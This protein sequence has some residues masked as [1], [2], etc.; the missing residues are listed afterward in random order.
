MVND[1]RLSHKRN[2]GQELSCP[3]NSKKF[4]VLKISGTF[5]SSK[6]PRILYEKF[7]KIFSRKCFNNLNPT[8]VLQECRR[9]T[10]FQ[11]E[12]N[13][14]RFLPYIKTTSTALWIGVKLT[15]FFTKKF[16]Y[17]EHVYQRLAIDI[18]LVLV[19]TL[20]AIYRNSWMELIAAPIALFPFVSAI[21]DMRSMLGSKEEVVKS[22]VLSACLL[23]PSMTEEGSSFLPCLSVIF[24]TSQFL[25][26]PEKLK[27]FLREAR[28]IFGPAY[29]LAVL[30]AWS[31][32]VNDSSN[33]FPIL[34]LAAIS[35]S[36]AAIFFRPDNTEVLKWMQVPVPTS[37]TRKFIHAGLMF[38][39]FG[40]MAVHCFLH[41]SFSSSFWWRGCKFF[42]G[43]MIMMN[44]VLFITGTDTMRRFRRSVFAIFAAI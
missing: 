10:F 21:R 44:V 12:M 41:Q 3:Q 33:I 35:S 37:L 30:G 17:V 1:S 14:S 26:W 20:K 42:V 31:K 8:V 19:L 43:I 36:A 16:N 18:P 38:L 7:L 4:L 13:F 29:V 28:I 23:A 5:L 34:P 9:V 32:S 22:L 15:I 39:S 6:F 2:Q 25:R 11:K 40:C 27:E 24:A